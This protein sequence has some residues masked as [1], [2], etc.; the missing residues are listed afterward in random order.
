MPVD[1]RGVSDHPITAIIT[2]I[3]SAPGDRITGFEKPGERRL[4]P[5]QGLIVGPTVNS[6]ILV[7][8]KGGTR[9]AV[10][11]RRCCVIALDGAGNLWLHHGGRLSTIALNGKAVDPGSSRILESGDVVDVQTREGETVLRMGV[12][13]S[14]GQ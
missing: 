12:T 9:R 4:G 2:R 8:P 3:Y 10:G 11:G 1:Y 14:R 13:V 7:E 5:G 6:D